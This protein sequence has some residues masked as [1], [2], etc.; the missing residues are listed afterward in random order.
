MT[1]KSFTNARILAAGCSLAFLLPL[2]ARA[3]Q[4][5]K[6]TILTVNEEIQVQDKVLEPGTY[7]FRLLNSNADRHIV[8]I[9]NGDMSK[10]LDTI[11]AIPTYR[12]EPTGKSQF[13]F[14]E[15]PSGYAKAL[16]AWYYPGDNFGQAF[17]Y[18]K[19]LTMLAA[20]LT[21]PPAPIAA[22]QPEPQPEQFTQAPAPAAEP[23]PQEQPAPAPEIAQNEA[24]AQPA[25]P[26]PA[27]QS[28]TLPKTSSPYPLVGLLGLAFVGAFG[29]LRLK[30]TA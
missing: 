9:Y 24:P 18:P 25:S 16:H 5:D 20:A 27:P 15:T 22:P 30:R 14:Y 21:P 8:Q 13:K 4:W 12:L 26:E 10:C 17:T 2:A 29:V 6:K 3:D 23:V 7:V 11:A 1:L 19:H 28:N